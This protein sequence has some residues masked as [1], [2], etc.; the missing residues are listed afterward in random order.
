M[1]STYSSKSFS[2]ISSIGLQIAIPALLTKPSIETL[3]N[4]FVNSVR[5]FVQSLKSSGSVIT[6]GKSAFS[7]FKGSAEREIAYTVAPSLCKRSHK[8]RP[9]PLPI[10]NKTLVHSCAEFI[11][12]HQRALMSEFGQK[13]SK[14]VI[15]PAIWKSSLVHR[16]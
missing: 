2:V 10:I 5:V 14:G 4:R 3:F 12:M 8:S 7:S 15:R 11:Y 16:K 6:F 9:I 13:T 1:S